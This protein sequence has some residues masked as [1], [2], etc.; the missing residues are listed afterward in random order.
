MNA[1]DIA[2]IST[3]TL[4]DMARYLRRTYPTTK[5]PKQ[6]ITTHILIM[7]ELRKRIV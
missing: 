4:R 6:T 2:L 5:Y 3:P 1:H 7:A